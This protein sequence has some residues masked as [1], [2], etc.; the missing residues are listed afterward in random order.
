MASRIAEKTGL[1]VTSAR[2][3]NL[4]QHLQVRCLEQQTSPFARKKRTTENLQRI[5][6]APH[7]SPSGAVCKAKAPTMTMTITMI[8]HSVNSLQ[9]SA[10]LP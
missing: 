3:T 5:E 9:P 6:V 1:T 8:T 4:V 10:G 2:A 7:M